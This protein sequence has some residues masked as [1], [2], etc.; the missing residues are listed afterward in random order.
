M[1]NDEDNVLAAFH[2]HHMAHTDMERYHVNGDR[3]SDLE[4]EKRL[5]ISES[6]NLF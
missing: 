5:N 4:G 2:Y 6:Y 3:S 1:P